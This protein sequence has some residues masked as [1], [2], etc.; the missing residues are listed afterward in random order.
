MR[1]Q[2]YAT[3]SAE[4]G[5]P[6][7]AEESSRVELE[8]TGDPPACR[9]LLETYDRLLATLDVIALEAERV[10]DDGMREWAAL[11]G[12]DAVDFADEQGM[13]RDDDAERQVIRARVEDLNHWI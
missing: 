7:A 3:V 13:L 4:R 5:S 11:A 2:G 10:G 6:R 1:R 9:P 8:P 12:L